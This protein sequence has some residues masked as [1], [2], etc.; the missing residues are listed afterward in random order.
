MIKKIVYIGLLVFVIGLVAMFSNAATQN[1][2]GLSQAQPI[3]SNFSINASSFYSAP[4]YISN[5]SLVIVLCNFSRPVN[6]YLM[7]SSGLSAWSRSEGLSRAESLE[8]K[9]TLLIVRN[10]TLF[11][12]PSLQANNSSTHVLYSGLGKARFNPGTYYLVADNTNGSASSKDP[13]SG[14]IVYVPE[15]PNETT[16]AN[17]SQF[18]TQIAFGAVGFII[19]LAGIV[20]IVYG[21]MKAP[22]VPGR[23]DGDTPSDEEVD[24]LYSGVEKQKPINARNKRHATRK[25]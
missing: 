12:L 5:L 4:L 7:N 1:I 24:R 14:Q 16:Q 17:L 23:K 10:S 8:G 19:V 15:V 9:G 25:G 21:L 2:S 22:K 6:I 3:A 11:S 13:V 18:G 20:L